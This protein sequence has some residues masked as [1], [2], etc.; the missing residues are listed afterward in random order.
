[1]RS[2]RWLVVFVL[3]LCL[4]FIAGI[5]FPPPNTPTQTPVTVRPAASVTVTET[6]MPSGSPSPAA[7]STMAHA[8]TPT[9]GSLQG[10]VLTPT[11]QATPP[12]TPSHAPVTIHLI[13][14]MP[15]SLSSMTEKVIAGIIVFL[16]TALLG[17][18]ATRI[19]A[20]FVGERT[21]NSDDQQSEVQSETDP[22]EP[23]G[24]LDQAPPLP[25][26]WNV[27]HSRNRNFTGREDL[28]DALAQA[29][30]SGTPAALTQA[31]VGLGGVGKT[32]LALEYAY[33]HAADFDIVR[34]IRS[35]QTATLVGDY[36]ELGRALGLAGPDDTDLEAV[37]QVV[38][39]WLS[40]RDRWLLVLDNATSPEEIRPYLPPECTGQVIIT[41]R[42]RTGWRGTA[43]P[44]AVP[45]WPRDE[46]VDFLLR[47]TGQTDEQAADR[48]ADILGD[49][50]LAL[51]QAG[52]YIDTI[53]ISLD[54]YIDLFCDHQQ[55]LLSDWHPSDEY[56]APVL[57][58]WELSFT[59]V[60][61]ASPAAADFLN[62]CAFLAPDDI[63]RA[64]LAEGAEHLPR[65]LGEAVA[66]EFKLNALLEVVHRYSLLEVEGLALGM[67]RLVQAVARDRLDDDGRCRWAAVAVELL[68]SAFPYDEYDP[69]TWDTA[70]RLLPHALAAAG[71][72][73]ELD[74]APETAGRL[75]NQS[76][77]YFCTRAQFAEAKRSYQRALQIGEATYG[78]DHPNIAAAVNNLG[79]VLLDLGDLAAARQ[80]FE[81]ALKIDAAVYGPDH[82]AVARD[83]NNL[84]RVLHDLGD[85]A[86]ARQ[87]F[88]RALK[89]DEAVYGP[90]H[91]AVAIQ[92]NNL[93]IV[94]QD[95]GD[96]AAARQQ[97]E[98]ALKIDEAA[99]SPDHPTVARD[100]HNLGSVLQ[101]LGD[102]AAARQQFER[103]L[104]I[105]DTVYGKDHPETRTVRGNLET[106][107]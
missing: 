17:W 23:P 45:T 80:A 75:L 34:W 26:H 22:R 63:P 51:E 66:D 42:C 2:T 81:R 104:R 29:L 38:R 15:L 47:R 1:M 102:L 13:P 93:G 60:R 78:P 5:T 64:L 85:L 98:R 3:L 105:M 27:P 11:S 43:K 53:G 107:G 31:I 39:R 67:H 7:T 97:F 46:S 103:A 19:W 69:A 76:G 40:G 25:Q 16:V 24:T 91:P 49:L 44:L 59:R 65:E 101:D 73:E 94:L 71:H 36:A 20:R 95:L 50:P 92:V 70:E 79:S 21:G 62:L 82:P 10:G 32:Q 74:A 84:G 88:E 6:P 72:S 96:L 86:G 33:R 99:F 9:T 14:G 37:A 100:V 35:E 89:I 61:D 48:L 90:D 58:T 83:L 55:A 54:K 52:A 56:P 4:P 18:L 106:L 12:P 87:A 77:G 68:N 57:T 8:D 30:S 41:S 28:L